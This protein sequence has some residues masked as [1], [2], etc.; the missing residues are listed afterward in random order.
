MMCW[1]YIGSASL[2]SQAHHGVPEAW[3]RVLFKRS[4]YGPT[5]TRVL[6]GVGVPSRMVFD[7]TWQQA[8]LFEAGWYG[9]D[10]DCLSMFSEHRR[11]GGQY[12]RS[13]TGGS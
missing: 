12:P 7:V 1:Y 6:S 5:D 2:V 8:W 3:D 11:G 4:A 13:F 9:S 10:G